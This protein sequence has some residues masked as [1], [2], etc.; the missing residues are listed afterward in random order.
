V[1]DDVLVDNSAAA[2]HAASCPVLH[3]KAAQAA[4]A[5]QAGSASASGK[6]DGSGWLVCERGGGQRKV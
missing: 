1:P 4:V 2:V 5:A 3:K 6:V